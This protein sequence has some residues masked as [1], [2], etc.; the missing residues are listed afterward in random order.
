MA[1]RNNYESSVEFANHILDTDL[2]DASKL[3]LIVAELCA[4]ETTLRAEI[5]RLKQAIK[6]DDCIVEINLEVPKLRQ[7]ALKEYIKATEAFYKE[8]NEVNNA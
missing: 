6:P 5:K 8:N 4:C 1:A 3:A 2:T 7:L